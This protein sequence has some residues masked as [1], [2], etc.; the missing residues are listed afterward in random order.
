MATPRIS[1]Q[2]YT[3][4]SVL[5]DDLDGGIARLAAIGFDTIEAFD[6]V[7]RAPALK[8]AFEKNGI[9]PTTGHAFF[10]SD[11][12]H[13]P[14]GTVGALPAPAETFAAAKE[15][16]LSVV[17][18]PYVPAD[19]WATRAGVEDTAAR[20]NAAAKEAAEH[21]LQ[22]GYHNHDHE[23]R[24]T[25]DGKPAYE[26]FASLLNDDV[27]LELDLYWATA[28]GIDVTE[29]LPRLGDK[30]IAVHVKDGP[31][32][33]E[34]STAQLPTDQRPAGQGDVP[35]AAGIEAATALQYAVIEFDHFDGDIFDG[36]AQSFAW[37]QAELGAEVS[38]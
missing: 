22:V 9:E 37:L 34:I 11:E 16:G 23:F 18:D 5:A 32:A 17:I 4:N 6:F 35:L 31:M 27:K 36:V 29:L 13:S 26:L 25:I 2:M 20:L 30:V 15:L 14:D 8:A 7:G 10:L 3:V 19:R 28:A 33:G 21:G 12:I 38:A 24:A 1:L